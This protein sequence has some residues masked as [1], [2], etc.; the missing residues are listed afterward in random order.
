MDEYGNAQP[1]AFCLTEK[2]DAQTLS[3]MLADFLVAVRALRP[4][5]WPSCFLADDD[6]AEHKAI[7]CA[8][9]SRGRLSSWASLH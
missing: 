8:P 5:W 1:V 4:D 3:G 9:P 6:A 7:R 2:D